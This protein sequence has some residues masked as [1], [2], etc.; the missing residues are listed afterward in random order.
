VTVVVLI[1]II[2]C[3]SKVAGLV[4]VSLASAP[5]SLTST[6]PAILWQRPP[7]VKNVGRI[8]PITGR[9]GFLS[10]KLTFGVH[11]WEGFARQEAPLL[12]C[13]DNW[14]FSSASGGFSVENRIAA[15]MDGV[16]SLFELRKLV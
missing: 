1:L 3:G 4:I 7:D 15:L 9:A 16:F 2:V 5:W 14:H 13:L 10:G 11:D 8:K 12:R 6:C